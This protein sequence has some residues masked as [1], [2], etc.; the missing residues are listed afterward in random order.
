MGGVGRW[1]MAPGWVGADLSC[2]EGWPG[3]AVGMAAHHSPS[4][5]TTVFSLLLPLTALSLNVRLPPLSLSL[6][7]CVSAICLALPG[8]LSYRQFHPIS[9]SKSHHPL[10]SVTQTYC[11]PSGVLTSAC[12]FPPGFPLEPYCSNHRSQQFGVNL[13]KSI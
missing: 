7:S 11:L 4:T 6:P 3:G 8:S 2:R 12:L 1:H 10:A 5:H 9:V 13:V